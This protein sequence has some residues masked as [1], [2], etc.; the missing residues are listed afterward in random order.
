MAL[1]NTTVCP[2]PWAPLPGPWA[3][4]TAAF[5]VKLEELSQA[6]LLHHG[7]TAQVL[8]IEDLEEVFQLGQQLLQGW[9]QRT[10]KTFTVAAFSSKA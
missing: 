10:Q 9:R 8:L 2:G 4:L 5:D 6:A 3:T 1:V 7:G